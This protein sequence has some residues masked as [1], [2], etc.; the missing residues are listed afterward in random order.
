[1]TTTASS[2]PTS[3]KDSGES[4][5]AA[6][7]SDGNETAASNVRKAFRSYESALI[8]CIRQAEKAPP[9]ASSPDKAGGNDPVGGSLDIML[10]HRQTLRRTSALLEG[11]LRGNAKESEA[12]HCS[13]RSRPCVVGGRKRKFSLLANDKDGVAGSA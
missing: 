6:K 13:L 4:G 2:K 8:V 1:M 7:P 10:K 5:G 11:K 9:A 3:A 12:L